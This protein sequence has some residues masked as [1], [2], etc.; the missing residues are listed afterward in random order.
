MRK[1]A[2][3]IE[4]FPNFFSAIFIDIDTDKK[5]I[6]KYIEYDIN[7]EYEKKQEILKEIKPVIFIITKEHNDYSLLLDF[8]KKHKIIIGYNNINYDDLIID[9]LI[10]N[11][12]K[13]NNKGFNKKNGNHITED[14]FILSTDIIDYGH[15]YRYYNEVYKYF[16]PPYNTID[17]QKLLYLDKKFISLKQVAVQ[18]KWYRLQD[19][20]LPFNKPVPDDMFYDLIDYNINDVLITYKLYHNQINEV[21]LRELISKLYKVDV[22]TYSRSGT[23]NKLLANFYSKE[24]GLPIKDFI[25]KR[26]QRRVIK[27]ED[28]IYSN[29]SFKSDKL[30]NFLNKMKSIVLKVGYDKFKEDIIFNNKKYGFGVGGLHSSDNPNIYYKEDDKY[31]IDCDVTSYYPYGIVNNKVH[32]EHLDKDIFIN[33]GKRII[34]E[35]VDA[36]AFLK[37]IKEALKNVENDVVKEHYDELKKAKEVYYTKADGLKIVIN[38]GLFGKLGEENSFLNDLKAMYEVTINNQL[39]LMMLIEMLYYEG[40]DNVSA[41]T[42]GIVSIVPKNKVSTYYDVCE[43]WEQIT[44]FNLEYTNYEKYICHS[45]NNYIAVVDGYNKSNKDDIAKS[46]YIKQK[47]LFVTKIQIDKGYKHPIVPKALLLYYTDNIPIEETIY[48]SNDIYDFCIII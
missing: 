16:K 3:D 10:I 32:P 42:D 15:G 41:N 19:L 27:F 46:N 20:P 48:N 43:R 36:K 29:I 25:N 33:M 45:V 18:L 11:S 21:E 39:Y 8:F 13:Y 26:T 6:D 28:I 44:K 40:I 14:L 9:Y 37:Q 17:L 38:S 2:Y 30:N 31:L 47:G 35:R 5:L 23:A 34:N 7:K 4:V 1:Y 22:R 24:S 12:Y